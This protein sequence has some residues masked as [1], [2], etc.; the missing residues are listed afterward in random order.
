[1]VYG[2]VSNS[3]D[4]DLQHDVVEVKSDAS[5]RSCVWQ[6]QSVTEK[7]NTEVLLFMSLLH[8]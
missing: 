6:S 2:E 5:S 8:M 3:V 1:M 7:S 4:A